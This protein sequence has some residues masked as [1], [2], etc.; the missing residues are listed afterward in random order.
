MSCFPLPTFA[1]LSERLERAL[2]VGRD[3]I[4]SFRH[5]GSGGETV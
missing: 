5:S 4:L 2:E 1:A 3:A